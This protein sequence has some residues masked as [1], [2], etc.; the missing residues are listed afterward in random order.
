MTDQRP[1][2]RHKPNGP[3]IA[4]YPHPSKVTNLAH[5]NQQSHFPQRGF[6][7]PPLGHNFQQASGPPTPMSANSSSPVSWPQHSWPPSPPPRHPSEQWKSQALPTPATA[8][9]GLNQNMLPWQTR[10]HQNA[11]ARTPLARPG[12]AST[13]SPIS[14]QGSLSQQG[15]LICSRDAQNQYQQSEASYYSSLEEEAEESWWQELL[16][17]DY[18]ER[19]YESMHV[20][21]FLW[22]P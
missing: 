2:K 15:G 6:T 8:T 7:H 18:P 21:E 20:G 9:N 3:I 19:S 10:M 11:S 13:T 22:H 1:H 12:S 5:H 4:Q 16:A 14:R 17:L